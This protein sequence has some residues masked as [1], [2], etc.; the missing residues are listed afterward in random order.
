[1]E[2]I[3]EAAKALQEQ[4]VE[5]RRALH[6]IPEV[7]LDLP[8]SAAYI[9]SRLDELGIAW[10]AVDY[11]LTPEEEQKFLNAGFPR[12]KRSTGITADLG[13]GRPC[14]LLR[15]DFDALPMAE[16]NTD[17]PFCSK[18]GAMHACGH[19]SHAAMLLGAA[20]LLKDRESQLKGTVRLLFQPG[21]ELG[22]GSKT[23]VDMGVL[24]G[25][26]AAF[27]IHIMSTTPL[28][29][30]TYSTGVNS[31]SMDTYLIKIQGRGGHSSMPQLVVDPVNIMNQLYSALTVLPGRET[32]PRATVTLTCAVAH[33]GSAANIIPDTAELD[34]GMRTQDVE[35][36]RHLTQR[37]PELIDAYVK[38][39]RGSYAMEEFHTPM[40]VTDE[41]FCREV[42][43]ALNEVMGEGK[44]KRVEP[45][46]GTEDF[47]HITER[48]P[49]AVVVLGAGGQEQY[50]HH[51]PKMRLDERVF[52]QGAAMY[53]NC[54]LEWLKSK[55]K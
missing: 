3:L 19:D 21:E 30:V 53:A 44:V 13:S 33:S 47:G 55:A 45:M 54:A 1:M 32:D 39:W 7:G 23:M 22:C 9:K 52:Y 27:A 37:I 34:V 49:G 6:Q 42:L 8:E 18:N 4:I 24:D 41:G 20:K 40:T 15:A 36:R 29:E 50:A 38:A 51:H 17:L 31:S 11:A 43:P 2:G 16:E 35:A 25:V 28:G 10:R 26:D 12:M 46:A 48:V 14:I 5:D